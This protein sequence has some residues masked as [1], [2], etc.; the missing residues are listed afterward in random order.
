[1]TDCSGISEYLE[2]LKTAGVQ[3]EITTQENDTI[4]S[5]MTL[6][7]DG[8]TMKASDLGK[9]FTSKGLAEKG[10]NY[11]KDGDF[12]KAVEKLK[13]PTTQL[14]RE[15][16]MQ[17]N[18]KDHQSEQNESNQRNVSN[19]TEAVTARSSGIG[20]GAVNSSHVAVSASDVRNNPEHN[21]ETDRARI[22][23]NQ[24]QAAAEPATSVEQRSAGV[25]SEDEDTEPKPAQKTDSRSDNG[26][27]SSQSNILS[28]LSLAAKIRADAA[29][30]DA[31]ANRRAD[32][33]AD[34]LELTLC[35]FIARLKGGL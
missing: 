19:P 16:K 22:E 25:G 20:I 28:I 29:A 10:I 1:M 2:R 5:G 14:E 26:S 30:A 8:V 34:N 18:E 24:N 31:R 32:L 13:K 3:V 21:P 33:A 6:T 15:N 35:I 4:I 11:E 23:S 12:I 7:K 27:S 17:E 9:R